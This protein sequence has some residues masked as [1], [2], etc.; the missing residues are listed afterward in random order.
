MST[1]LQ[2]KIPIL[3]VGIFVLERSVALAPSFRGTLCREIRFTYAAQ[4]ASSSLVSGKRAY[5]RQRRIPGLKQFY[6]SRS[7]WSG[8][9]FWRGYAPRF[10]L[11]SVHLWCKGMP[12][13]IPRPKIEKLA[14]Q[15]KGVGI[16]AKGEYPAV[17][18]NKKRTFV[19]RQGCVF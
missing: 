17:S 2:N 6:F 8:F 1:H 11:G 12:V 7:L 19:Y 15:A 16:F 4:S 9:L 14:F 5:L 13:H 3:V 18:Y 10:E